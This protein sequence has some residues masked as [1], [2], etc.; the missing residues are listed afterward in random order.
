[1]VPLW[2]LLP[3]EIPALHTVPNFISAAVRS[4]VREQSVQPLTGRFRPLKTTNRIVV[5][6]QL[7]PRPCVR[8]VPRFLPPP[9]LFPASIRDDAFG[10]LRIPGRGEVC[11]WAEGCW[12]LCAAFFSAGWT[13]DALRSG[14]VVN[15]MAIDFTP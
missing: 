2:S 9:D 5:S 11:G 1:M 8:G 14:A 10:R 3:T 7:L 4:G 13:R 15:S 6:A 12:I